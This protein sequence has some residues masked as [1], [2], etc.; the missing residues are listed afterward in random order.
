MNLHANSSPSSTPAPVAST[1]PVSGKADGGAPGRA[2]SSLADVLRAFEA[3]RK[4][5]RVS[6]RL[7]IRIGLPGGGVVVA[8]THNMTPEG[9]DKVFFVNSGSEGNDTQVKI[10]WYYNNAL[11]RPEK[12]KIISRLKGYHG[13]TVAA[14]SM[15]GLPANHMDF[16][17]PIANIVHADSPDAPKR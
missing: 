7:P 10:V 9:L 1:P 6:M 14:A 15:T 4:Y 2:R 12:K 8:N 17:L 11:G 13:V 16:D 3:R 5:P